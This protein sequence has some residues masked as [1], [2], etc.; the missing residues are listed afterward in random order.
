[1]SSERPDTP[2]L[3]TD[4]ELDE[5]DDEDLPDIH[6]NPIWLRKILE[7]ES[8]EQAIP[9][10]SRQ[11]YTHTKY[12]NY[13]WHNVYYRKRPSIP[14]A[15]SPNPQ[16][17]HSPTKKI[18]SDE[19]EAFLSLQIRVQELLSISVK[20]RSDEEKKEYNR[21]RNKYAKDKKTYSYLLETHTAATGAQR[22]AASRE[23][24]T[25]EQRKTVRED[26]RVR[27]SQP[28]AQAATR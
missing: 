22:M 15:I 1:M 23:R 25:E 14:Q 11:F 17:L 19:E 26:D 7:P 8:N 27:K 16:N 20:N 24:M 3:L 18:R 9:G 13:Y 4:D 21:L 28:E 10:P 5:S 2:P 6:H 12:V